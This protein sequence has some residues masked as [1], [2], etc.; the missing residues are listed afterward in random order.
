MEVGY[1]LKNQGVYTSHAVSI[2]VDSVGYSLKNKGIYT[3][4]LLT[5]AVARLDINLK[6]KVFTPSMSKYNEFQHY[7][8]K[9]K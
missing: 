3:L 1:S 4:T 2:F 7:I 9:I 6:I 5:T 8:T